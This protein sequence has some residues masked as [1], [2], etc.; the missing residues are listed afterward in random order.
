MGLL[1][2][3][4]SMA[5]SVNDSLFNFN[6]PTSPQDA[7][8]R[9]RRNALLAASAPT[10]DF[11]RA[12]LGATLLAGDNAYTDA[13]NNQMQQ[14][15]AT[16]TYNQQMQ[17][18]NNL[19]QILNGMN[20]DA[21]TKLLLQSMPADQVS[22]ALSSIALTPKTYKYHFSDQYGVY[23]TDNKGGMQKIAEP[24][25]EWATITPEMVANDP[26]F[27]NLDPSKTYQ[28]NRNG[29][30]KE[31][32]SGGVNITNK[33]GQTFMESAMEE[34]FDRDL[35]GAMQTL[36][37]VEQMITLLE[38]GVQT[39]AGVQ[40]LNNF[41]KYLIT[42]GFDFDQETL[43]MIAKTEQF[44]ALS[45]NMILPLVKALGYNP[46][47]A[48]LR[49]IVEANPD[50]GKSPR[51]NMLLLRTLQRVKEAEIQIAQWED[52]YFAGTNN[53][54]GSFT[55]GTNMFADISS[56]QTFMR[57]RAKIKG[58]IM[59]EIRQRFKEDSAKIIQEDIL[60][61]VDLKDMSEKELRAISNSNNK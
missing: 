34:Y 16:N 51:G 12:N 37:K 40:A 13:Y 11:N 58:E 9:A 26:Q 50:L 31:V 47:D 21:N 52:A 2:T 33:T 42:A 18:Q 4:N 35:G 41:K 56:Y 3:L 28:I 36:G 60:E 39:G 20:L 43:D 5:S 29:Q 57:E 61:P 24:G 25:A 48:D 55:P 8:E 19:P 15:I 49:F 1:D 30:I 53:P 22:Q 45:K 44:G 27:A 54:D 14:D 17:L 59:R 23:V 7:A 46:T 10:T 6:A 32:G 38:E